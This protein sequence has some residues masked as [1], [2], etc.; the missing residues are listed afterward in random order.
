MVRIKYITNVRIPTPRAQGYA[1]MKMCSEFSK[2]Y[3]VTLFVPSRGSLNFGDD[4]FSF[5]KLERNFEIKKVSSFDLLGITK[6]FGKVFYWID[7]LSFF[8]IS[9]FTIELNKDDILYT[10]DFI[11]AI[12]YPNHKLS[13]LELHDIPK[14]KFLFNLAIKKYKIFF[15]LNKNLKDDLVSMGIPQNKIFISPSGVEL[16]EFD[17]DIDKNTARSELNLPLDKKI[18]MYTGH[19]YEWKGADILAEVA[20]S[21]PDTLFVFVGGV[22]PELGRFMDTYKDYKNIVVYPFVERFLVPKYLK[23]ADV[24]VVPNSNKE[25]ISV[26]YTSPLKL[27]EYMASKRPIVASDLPSMREILN[28]SNCVFAEPMKKDSFSSSINRVLTDEELAKS[29]SEKAFIDVQEYT[30]TKRSENILRSITTLF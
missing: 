11:T 26:R 14:S 21:M 8:V 7:V 20:K 16:K 15:V 17:I 10:R 4:P 1:I 2:A 24:L 9:K 6:I 29:L 23:S 5:Y 13:V 18:V 27:F 28:D 22:E 12:F 19:L 3:P 25:A 30:W